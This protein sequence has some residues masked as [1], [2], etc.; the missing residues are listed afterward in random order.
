MNNRG[1]AKFEVLTVIVLLAVIITFL[2]TSVLKA[3]NNQKFNLMVTDAKNFSKNIVIDTTDSSVYYLRDAIKD[4][5]Y[6]NIRS[7]FSSNNCDVNESKIEFNGTEKYVTLKCDK[8]LIYNEVSSNDNFSIYKVSKWLSSKN[9]DNY[10][11]MVGYN[12]EK[13]GKKVF[14]EY[15]EEANFLNYVNEMYD[16]EYFSVKDI[17]ECSVVQKTFF[18]DLKVVR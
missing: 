13:D 17:K 3:V 12:C 8:Y 4:E 15:Y 7:P 10:Q 2:L 14:K 9:S 18:R 16:K 6:D 11:K 1:F 5:L